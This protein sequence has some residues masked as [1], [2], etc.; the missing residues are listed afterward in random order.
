M[1]QR[2]TESLSG[3][4]PPLPRTRPPQVL[5]GA[6]SVKEAMTYT[7]RLRLRHYGGA[8]QAS[9]TVDSLL[10]ELGLSDVANSPIGIPW[11]SDFE[12]PEDLFVKGPPHWDPNKG[13]LPSGVR[14]RAGIAPPVLLR[15]SARG[16]LSLPMTCQRRTNARAQRRVV[17]IGCELLASP[18]LVLLDE[19]TAGLDAASAFHVVSALRRLTRNDGTS[20]VFSR[21]AIVLSITQP[22]SEARSPSPAEPPPLLQPP[23][24]LRLGSFAHRRP[25]ACSTFVRSPLRRCT[26]SSTRSTSSPTD[27]RCTSARARAWSPSSGPQARRARTA[28]PP[29]PHPERCAASATSPRTRGGL[30]CPASLA[31]L[32]PAHLKRCCAAAAAPPRRP[33]AGFATPRGRS[34]S[35]HMLMTINPYFDDSDTARRGSL[36]CAALFA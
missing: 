12:V 4:S 21:R 33:T 15:R 13:G 6:L 9:R 14:R 36:T 35:D 2:T 34:I 27:T 31:H 24:S 29:P 8:P 5:P 16:G 17:S 11:A 1:E 28:A 18:C 19:P 23:H 25:A 22:T 20:T 3:P 10:A 30:A 26:T 7:A 32:A